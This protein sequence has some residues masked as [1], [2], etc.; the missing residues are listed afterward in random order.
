MHKILDCIDKELHEVEEKGLTNNNL[1]VTYKLLKMRDLIL[2]MED[3][4][5]KEDEEMRYRGYDRGYRDGYGRGYRGEDGYGRGGRYNDYDGRYSRGGRYG[6][7]FD[8]SYD[9]IDRMLEALD[10]YCYGRTRYREGGSNEHMVK[11]LEDLM[12]AVCTFVEGLANN[13]ETPADKEIIRK[14]IEKLSKI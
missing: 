1:E 9:K 13:A 2:N 4:D 6:D 8:A 10:D 12:Y 7:D 14:H 5:G 3:F 11:G